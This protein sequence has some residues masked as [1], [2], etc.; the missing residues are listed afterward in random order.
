MGTSAGLSKFLKDFSKEKENKFCVFD[1]K[2]LLN[3][4]VVGEV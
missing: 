3:L 4:N 2:N 1:S